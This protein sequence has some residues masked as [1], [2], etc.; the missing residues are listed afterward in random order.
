M[1]QN[2]ML[3]DIT[4]TAAAVI[5]FGIF[6]LPSGFVLGWA[7]NVLG[8]GSQSA[9]ERLLISVVLSLATTPILAV[10]IGRLAS[11]KTTLAFFLLLSFAACV[12][13]CKEVASNG[14]WSW[15]PARSTAIALGIVGLWAA[16]L[17]FSVIDIQVGNRLYVSN[18][19]YDHSVR[20]PFVEAAARTGVPPLNPFYDLGKV[21][22]LRYFYYWYVV[23]SLPE[24]LVGLSARDCFH[25]SVLWSAFALA[26]IIPLYLK[27]FFRE[28]QALRRKSLIGISL[29]FVTG[30]DLLPYTALCIWKHMVDGDMEGW[31]PN[32]VTSWF[33]S[34]I[35][36]PHHVAALTAC[37][38]GLLVLLAP[39]ERTGTR[40]RSWSAIIAAL[41]FASAAGLSVLVAFTFGVFAL[42]WT[43]IVLTQ[44][45]FLEFA[46]FVATGGLTVLL[47]VPF[48][49]DLR[50]QSK[51][52]DKF[53]SFA[54]RDYPLALYWLQQW[55]IHNSILLE[56]SKLPV[57]I[58]VYLLEFGFFFG[59]GL[60][61][62]NRELL[63]NTRL[64]QRRRAAWVML[65][66]C[67]LIVSTLKSNATGANDLGFRGMLVVQFVLLLWAAPL[68]HDLFASASA[69]K[70]LPTVKPLWRYVLVTTLVLGV[71]G[72]TYQIVIMR[73][74]E[75][76]ADAG[77]I[78]R[79][80]DFMGMSPD[81]GE[82]TYRL[83][84]GFTQLAKLTTPSSVLQFNPVGANALLNRLYSTHQTVAGDQTCGTTFGGDPDKC[85]EAMPYLLSAFNSPENI[86]EWNIDEFCDAF[87]ANLLVATEADPV[88]GDAGSWVWSKP[89]LTSNDSMRS[90]PCGSG[91]NRLRR[92]ASDG[93][94]QFIR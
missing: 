21:P 75:P 39:E 9:S 47:S 35:W 4:G 71:L 50:T 36:V 84:T 45:R 27:H 40:E 48:I 16:I 6:F 89:A 61:Q 32:Q 80:E 90:I 37:M 65:G 22:V 62:F 46:T 25:A 79:T 88:W 74:Y 66:T 57:L 68:V 20:I 2:Y 26:A 8:F 42:L 15:R 38:A 56:L 7:S 59:I 86:R 49:Q 67:L 12:L 72:T 78:H 5:V 92:Q 69:E 10:L 33:G 3:A 82:R 43:N 64:T 81:M 87:S 58:L 53:A 14:R 23:C 11:V 70:R 93:Q 28:T 51:V 1:M 55:G 17:L 41:A 18:P 73:S 19:V 77:I 34:I 29:L 94:S 91:S 76:L 63:G 52:G 31:D 83:R 24:R 13:A 85:A 54:I 44:R 30:L 60:F